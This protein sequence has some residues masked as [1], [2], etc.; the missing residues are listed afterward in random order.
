[1]YIFIIGHNNNRVKERGNVITFA[2]FRSRYFM[3]ATSC[4]LVLGTFT[5][6]L[7]ITDT[8]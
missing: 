7:E 4:V 8:N 6:D 2:I 5:A 1:M 3:H